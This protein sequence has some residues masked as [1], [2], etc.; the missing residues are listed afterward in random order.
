[1]QNINLI[2]S[3][4]MTLVLMSPQINS[5]ELQE[6]KALE[7]QAKKIVKSFG[8]TLKPKLKQA[9]QSGGLVNAINVCASQ[10][11][12]IA[13]DLSIKTGWIVRRVSLKSRNS[14]ATPDAFERIVLESFDQRQAQG[15]PA[16]TMSYSEKVNNQYRFIKP[17]GVEPICLGCHGKSVSAD[18][19]SA[20]KKH[21]P[22]DTATDYSLGQ[23]RGA[24]SL[25]KPLQSK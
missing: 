4:I 22:N 14:S 13:K 5:E 16:A 7:I 15:E 17:Q 1:M 10:A 19:K 11:P 12:K 2:F 23:I 9:I 3:A 20:L 21:Y 18:V 8:G 25:I 24:F 6:N